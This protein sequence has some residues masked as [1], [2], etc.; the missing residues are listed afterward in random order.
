[1][2]MVATDIAARGIDI[3]DVTHVINFEVPN[4]AESY[5]H[6]IGRTARAGAEGIAISFC[7]GEER[8]FIADIEKL[9]GVAIPV[10]IDQPFHSHAVASGRLLSKGKAKAMIEAN[11]RG[12]GRRGG[13]GGGGNRGG[14]TTRRPRTGG[15]ATSSASGPARSA[16]ASGGGARRA[17][18][19]SPS[20]SA[21]SRGPG[22]GPSPK[23]KV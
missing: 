3:D 7:D 10:T 23:A 13:A 15:G 18:I 9:T 6:R 11:D 2:L 4:V 14:G 5:V 12:G 19:P 17:A 20:G 21:P 1:M 22:P 8:S 16:Q